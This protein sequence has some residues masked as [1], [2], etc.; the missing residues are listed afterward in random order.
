LAPSPVD[1]LYTKDYPAVVITDSLRQQIAEICRREAAG[2]VDQFYAFEEI[3]PQKLEKAMIHY[4]PSMGKDETVIFLY[5]E[6]IAG[7][8]KTGFI[9]TSKCL[10]SKSNKESATRSYIRNIVKAIDLSRY[11][12]AVEMDT[13]NYI[14]ISVTGSKKKKAAILRVLD[15]TIH[16]LKSL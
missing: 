1:V 16:L 13:G 2:A 9:L 4:A 12:I 15:E 7:S 8:A 10:Y 3:P 11:C 14:S 5:D 6:T